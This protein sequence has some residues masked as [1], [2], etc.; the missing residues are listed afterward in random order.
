M[1][2]R[3]FLKYSGQLTLAS[4]II[5]SASLAH[6]RGGQR[7]ADGFVD[8]EIAILQGLTDATRTQI[9][10]QKAKNS[11]FY[12][13]ARQAGTTRYLPLMAPEQHDFP[14]SN[15]VLEKVQVEE[16]NP[17]VDYTFEIFNAD[18]DVL[19]QR[20]F[21][22]LDLEKSQARFAICSCAADPLAGSQGNMWDSV[23]AAKPEMIFFIGDLCYSDF[24]GATDEAK[25]W[26]RFANSRNKLKY[27]KM[28]S[29]IPTLFT[30]DDH[31]FGAN[32]TGRDY[33]Y[34]TGSTR[35][36]YSYIAQDPFATNSPIV[37]GPGVANSFNAFGLNFA[38]MD[39]RT[40]RANRTDK[41]DLTHWGQQ[42]EEWLI[43]NLSTQQRPTFLLNGS[44]V[45]GGYLAKDSYEY[46]HPQSLQSMLQRIQQVESPVIFG[47]G[48]VH[49]SEVMKLEKSLLG[50]ESLEIVSSG[51]HAVISPFGGLKKN[52]R[53]LK[54]QKA[55][56]FTIV[57][58]SDVTAS[59]VQLD[60][61]SIGTNS[62]IH[63]QH[64]TRVDRNRT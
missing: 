54:G 3:E 36:F 51:I 8:S 28:K 16:L 21:R 20:S 56:N 49:F 5:G 63:Y 19:D 6:G 14:G 1:Q 11:D 13:R 33:P 58:T 10:V 37:R 9:S 44:Q 59:G 4:S 31:D 39:D 55:L 7:I 12:Y 18:G 38:L 64:S 26:A 43:D 47:S 52:P 25:L 45:F 48:D 57:E 53:R 50:Y 23:V 22:S 35:N 46:N 29:L 2:R 41:Q 32:N 17:G 34:I 42:Q 30:W 61:T 15:I 40:F 27:Y 62:K 24:Y 60:I